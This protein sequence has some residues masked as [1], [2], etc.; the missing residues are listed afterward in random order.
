MV[1]HANRLGRVEG[2]RADGSRGTHALAGHRFDFIGEVANAKVAVA[3]VG[4]SHLAYAGF[5]EAAEILAALIVETPLGGKLCGLFFSQLAFFT[6]AP[7]ATRTRRMCR[8]G[9]TQIPRSA[10]SW[11]MS[12]RK[13]KRPAMS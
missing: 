13:Q 9:L 4:A 12:G 5:D 3:G 1:A 7:A 2:C 11:A 8:V 10:I 6:V